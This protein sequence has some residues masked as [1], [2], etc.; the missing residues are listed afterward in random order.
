MKSKLFL[1]DL[2]D[3]LSV[4]ESI[5]KLWNSYFNFIIKNSHNFKTIF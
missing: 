2:K 1:I 3:E 5:Y 4:D